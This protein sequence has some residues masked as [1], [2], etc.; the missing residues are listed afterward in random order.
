MY[1]AAILVQTVDHPL[2][3]PTT[4]S[5]QPP[6]ATSAGAA[7]GAAFGRVGALMSHLEQKEVLRLKASS[8]QPATDCSGIDWHLHITMIA[9]QIL[10][11]SKS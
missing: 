6:T 7:G 11:L 10:P 2:L 9:F 3:S 1:S 8:R 4:L 5:S